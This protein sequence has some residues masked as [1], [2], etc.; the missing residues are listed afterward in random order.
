[1]LNDFEAIGY[2][3]PVV[4]EADLVVL[5]DA[6]VSPKVGLLNCISYMR[7]EHHAMPRFRVSH[8]A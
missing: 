6:P 5:H 3:V 8:C 4:P 2:G 1:V 7:I